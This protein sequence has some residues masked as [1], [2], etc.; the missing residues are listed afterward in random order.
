MMRCIGMNRQQVIHFLELEALNWCRSAVPAGILLGTVATWLLVAF[1]HRF[2]GGEFARLASFGVSPAGIVSGAVVGILTVLLAARAPAKK[3][4]KVS[5]VAAVS[6]NAD[7][8]KVK[9]HRANTRLLH[10]ETALGVSHAAASKKGLFLMAGS[11]ALNIILFLCFSVFADLLGI[12]LPTKSYS[13]DIDINLSESGE[14]IDPGL[15]ERLKGMPGV[16]NAF[17]RRLARSVPA[18]FSAA[19]DRDVV[20]ILSYDDIQLDWI[21]GDG[22]LR[23]GG[24]LSKVYGDQGYVLCI[25]DKDVPLTVGDKI[26]LCGST[27]EIAGMMTSNPFSNNGRTDGDVILMGVFI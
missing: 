24:D 9:P 14:L 10:I 16:K 21:P 2:A 1:M 6:G 15:M 18:E 17:G 7:A 3:A 26:T 12:M 23:K 11:F 13:S 22:D 8:G 19:A 5:P 27:V 4:A 25:W 20:D